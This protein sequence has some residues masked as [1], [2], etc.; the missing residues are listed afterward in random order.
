MNGRLNF[1][2]GTADPG[3]ENRAVMRFGGRYTRGPVRLDGALV[4][5]GGPPAGRIGTIT[6]E[7][8]DPMPAMDSSTLLTTIDDQLV[9]LGRQ[10]TAGLVEGAGEGEETSNLTWTISNADDAAS[11][12]ADGTYAATLVVTCNALPFA[13]SWR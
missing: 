6:D 2:N 11:G 10:L 3:A 13:S 12:L 9:P 5:V 7:P 4:S 1:T 8:V